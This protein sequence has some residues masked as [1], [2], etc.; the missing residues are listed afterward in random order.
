VGQKMKAGQKMK[1]LRDMKAQECKVAGGE[2]ASG[3]IL[4]AFP[5][6]QTMSV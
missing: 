2:I 6:L 1:V 4:G 3:Q 5:D